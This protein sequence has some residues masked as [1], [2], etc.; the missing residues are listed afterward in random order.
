MDMNKRDSQVQK[1]KNDE[2]N[3]KGELFAV[4]KLD[5][6]AWVTVPGNMVE[7]FFGGTHEVKHIGKN[8]ASTIHAFYHPEPEEESEP[9]VKTKKTKGGDE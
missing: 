8:D 5:T 4:R 1:L 2:L 7:S 9:V 6:E 3:H